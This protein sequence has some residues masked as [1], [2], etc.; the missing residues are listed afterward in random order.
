MESS[1]LSVRE[2]AERLGIGPLAVRRH[3]ASGRL[4]AVKRG[5]D[6]WLDARAVERLARERRDGGRPL[7]PAMAWAVLLL[8]SNEEAA[9][10]EVAGRDRYWSRARAWL[11]EHPLVEHAARLR[12]RA[13]SEE[14]D[15]HPSELSRIVR[16][17]DVI[18]TGASAADAIGVVGLASVVEIYAP[19]GHRDAI[20]AEHA[21]MP[22]AGSVLVRWVPDELWPYLLGERDR[23]AP[24]AA[25]LLDLLE[26]DEP[27][28]RREAARGLAS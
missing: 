7:S 22:G 21:L 11:R 3:I 10:R 13:Q 28:A 23:R 2:A 16:R 4:D 26:S 27:R 9:A 12:G 19:V 1:S 20:V 25:V 14:F 24:R 15:A 6:W 8:A 17:P 18:A 5:R